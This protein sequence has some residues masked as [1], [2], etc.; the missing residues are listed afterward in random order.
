VNDT[1]GG[2]RRPFLSR[3]SELRAIALAR[4]QPESTSDLTALIQRERPRLV[5]RISRD[6]VVRARLAGTRHRLVGVDYREAKANGDSVEPD[7]Q[8]EIGFFDY[9]HNTLVVAVADLRSGTVRQVEERRGLQ[10]PLSD[11]ELEDARLILGRDK[12]YKRL[13]RRSLS[14]TALPA[15]AAF[16]E[17]HPAYGHRCFAVSAWSGRRAPKLEGTVLVDLSD[18]RLVPGGAEDI[19]QPDVGSESRAD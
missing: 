13:A 3:R 11:E 10:P 9:D 18:R 16:S 14:L 15:R 12:A 19:R 2:G 6:P 7:R 4:R 17:E 5:A 8:V 1:N